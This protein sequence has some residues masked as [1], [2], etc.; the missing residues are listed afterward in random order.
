MIEVIVSD[1]KENALACDLCGSRNTRHVARYVDGHN[2]DSW[3]RCLS[4][5]KEYGAKLHFAKTLTGKIVIAKVEILWKR[6]IQE[7]SS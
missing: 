3:W 7:E 6:E 5:K 2:D 1:L 4:C